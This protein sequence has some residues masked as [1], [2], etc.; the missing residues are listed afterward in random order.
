[1]ND[2]SYWRDNNPSM[3]QDNELT[4][5]VNVS[6]PECKNEEHPHQVLTL[7]EQVKEIKKTVDQILAFMVKADNTMTVIATEI[8]PAVDE[9][10]KSP[11]LKMLGVGKKK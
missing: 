6:L 10:M 3:M 8:M 1:M 9:I 7:E 2:I 11:M 4:Q 5:C